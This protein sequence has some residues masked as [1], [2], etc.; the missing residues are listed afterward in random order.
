MISTKWTAVLA[1]APLALALVAVQPAFT[2]EQKGDAK[3]A[4]EPAKKG[5]NVDR[6][7]RG[8]SPQSQAVARAALADQLARYGD[9]N[10]D[11]M[12]LIT[13]ARIQAQL[14]VQEAKAD[15]TTEGAK[16]D[17]KAKP[18]GAARD[19]TVE[20]LL[21][22]AKQYA[23]GRKD[24]IALADEVA[25]TGTRGAVGG[26]KRSVTDVQA[27]S[28]DIFNVSFRGGEPAV[29][30]ISGDGD[31]DLDL[32]VKDEN[33][34]VVCRA[35]GASDDEICRWTPR[36]TGSFRIEVQNLGNVYNRYRIMT[37]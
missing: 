7:K 13:A 12:A 11:A 28:R 19:V 20:G 23:G 26:P 9:Q 1:A 32:V 3:K 15:K 4:A 31:T 29:V 16:P 34:N 25:K 33:G 2:A 5:D 22:R 6:D 36:W 21:A 18:A 27:R 30:A 10:K 17:P 35:D 8:N 24:L 14:G 37:N